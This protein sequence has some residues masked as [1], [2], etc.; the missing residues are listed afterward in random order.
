[1][2]KLVRMQTPPCALPYPFTGKL[3]AKQT[4][5][6]GVRHSA[7]TLVRSE[8]VLPLA[9]ALGLVLFVVPAVLV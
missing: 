2:R 9:L 4:N 7:L 8:L 1:M 3:N 5:G 6:A